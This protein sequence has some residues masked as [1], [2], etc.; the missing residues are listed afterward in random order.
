ML[1]IVALADQG[2]YVAAELCLIVFL[3]ILNGV[4]AGAEIAVVSVE[5]TR[6]AQLAERGDRR[7]LAVRELRK[8]PEQFFA[9]VQIGI[10]L[11]GATAAAFGGSRF[12]RHLEPALQHVEWLRPVAPQL[13]FA[14]V[15]VAIAFLSVIFGELVPKSLAVRHAHGY[16]LATGPMILFLSKATRP[17]VSLFTAISNAVLRLFG[18]R[19]A[20]SEIRMSPEDLQLLV[21][22]AAETGSIHPAAGEIA[23]RA[24]EFADLTASEVMVPRSR[25]V[26][27]PETASADD[28]RRIVTEQAYSRFPVYGEHL[29][30]IKGYVLVKDLLSMAFERQLIILRDFTRSPY[31][32]AEGIKAPVILQEMRRRRT[33]LAFVVDEHGGTSGIVTMEDLLEELVGEIF[34]EIAQ[35][36]STI[37]EL[38]DGTAV[39]H[40]DTPLRKLN[41]QLGIELPESDEWSTLGGLCLSL[42]GRIPKQGQR[43]TSPDGTAL[44]IQSATE[45]RV[46][47][48]KLWPSP[49]HESGVVAHP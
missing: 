42:A 2:S 37:H 35:E 40:G 6:L 29:D 36:S 22:E 16:A 27:I 17:L 10:T 45:R 32:V 44:E 3:I 46:V 48:V 13:S 11:I 14:L 5:R 8:K 1:A 33:H 9:A 19:G 12:A 21:S 28:I 15:V 31:I 18:A 43:L 26:G 38:S 7:A 41:R 20:I 4:L 34:S 24:L 23:S 39:A 47:R 30:D 49:K 25:V